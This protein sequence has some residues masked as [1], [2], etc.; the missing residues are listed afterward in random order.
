MRKIVCDGVDCGIAEDPAIPQKE[1]TIQPI[2]L[3][4]IV[5]DR[6]NFPE[7]T[8]LYEADLCPDCQGRLLHNYF[9]VSAKGQLTLPA[10]MEPER[11][12]MRVVQ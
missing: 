8:T 2:R 7:S 4:I 5:D 12:S 6:E 11:H 10:F 9:N 1:R 3:T